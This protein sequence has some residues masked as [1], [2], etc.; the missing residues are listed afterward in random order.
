MRCTALKYV[1]K[2]TNFIM[3]LLGAAFL[4]TSADI[5]VSSS[6]N[7][8]LPSSWRK[9]LVL[10]HFVVGR[11]LT[12]LATTRLARANVTVFEQRADHRQ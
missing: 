4:V 1:K 3:A 10:S 11:S 2:Q 7:N 9:F 8:G 6:A 5:P 12:F